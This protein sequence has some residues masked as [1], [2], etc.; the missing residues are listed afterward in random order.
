MRIGLLSDTHGNFEPTKL[1]VEALMAAGAEMLIHCGDVGGTDILDLLAGEI[2]A[3][4]VFGNND[5]DRVELANY[6]LLLGIHCLNAFGEVDFG[7]GKKAVVLHGD[8]ASVMTRLLRAKNHAYLFHGHSHVQRDEQFG[9][10]RIINPGA[11][12][13]ATVKSV[14]LLDTSSGKLEFIP[15]ASAR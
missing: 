13:R 6:A 8:D 9:D 3:Y 12:H 11:L 5:W 7:D 2:P 10:T 1:G 14:A 15:I 4:F